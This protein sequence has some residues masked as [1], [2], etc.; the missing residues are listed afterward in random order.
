PQVS[1]PRWS[2]ATERRIGE[3]GGLFAKRRQTQMFNGYE[4]QVGQLYAGMDLR[5]FF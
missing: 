4:P 2:Q 1:H 5:K 3:E